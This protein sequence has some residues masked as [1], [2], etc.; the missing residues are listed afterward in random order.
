MNFEIESGDVLRLPPHSKSSCSS[1]L[2]KWPQGLRQFW[3]SPT[4]AALWFGL[5]SYEL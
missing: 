1:L 3:S 4:L 2:K 5:T